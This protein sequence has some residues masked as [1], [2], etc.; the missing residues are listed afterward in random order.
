MAGSGRR[1]PDWL[2]YIEKKKKVVGGH[3]AGSG[4]IRLDGDH[5][6]QDWLCFFFFCFFNQFD[7]SHLCNLMAQIKM[8]AKIIFVPWLRLIFPL[9]IY[10]YKIKCVYISGGYAVPNG[11]HES[12]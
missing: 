6:R 11:G 3:S 1:G 8:G 9:Y 12:S 5:R 2:P 7:L 4:R 10:I